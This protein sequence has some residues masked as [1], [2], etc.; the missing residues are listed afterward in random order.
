LLAVCFS[1]SSWTCC[2]PSTSSHVVHI[3]VRNLKIVPIYFYSSCRSQDRF[4]EAIETYHKLIDGRFYGRCEAPGGAGCWELATQYSALGFAQHLIH[5]D[6]NAEHSLKLS[7]DLTFGKHPEGHLHLGLMYTKQGKVSEAVSAFQSA[8]L[9]SEEASSVY[10]KA[11]SYLDILYR[12]EIDKQNILVLSKDGSVGNDN[13]Q[14]SRKNIETQQESTVHVGDQI[15]LNRR[16]FQKSPPKLFLEYLG[17]DGI[18]ETDLNHDS[19]KSVPAFEDMIVGDE[20]KNLLSLELFVDGKS[21]ILTFYESC[22]PESVAIQFF[23]EHNIVDAS[24]AALVKAIKVVLQR[25]NEKS[26]R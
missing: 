16:D 2:A 25:G 12:V 10:F 22:H 7:Q 11:N 19:L 8:K 20:T 14:E 13:A 23:K 4:E 1:R 9:V 18:N 21:N 26:G 6:E 17:D 15:D 3:A 5:D 24:T